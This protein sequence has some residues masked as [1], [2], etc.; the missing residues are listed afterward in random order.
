MK[1]LLAFSALAAGTVAT[2]RWMERW[3][4]RPDEVA[5]S[6]PGDELIAGPA[7]ETTMAVTVHADAERVWPWL[8]QL[9]Q[10]RGGMYS[11]D[12]L[13]QLVGLDIHSATEI[14]PEWQSL[15][16]GDRVQ[17]VPRG[18][19]P[20]PDGYAFTVATVHV[21][22]TLVLRQGPEPWDGVWS[23]ILRPEAAGRCRLISRTR[24]KSHAGMVGLVDRLATMIGTPVTWLMTRKMLLTLAQRAEAS[25]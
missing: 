25:A 24:T 7:L 11:Y 4:A 1:K 6:L 19:G 9:G 14:R 21:P 22:H 16:P 18:W 2:L 23:F 15:E 3:G 5:A 13:E 10:D 17:L 8:V 12:R 20:L